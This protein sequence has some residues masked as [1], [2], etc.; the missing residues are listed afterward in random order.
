M[1]RGKGMVGE[2]EWSGNG[3]KIN[4]LLLKA[5][6]ASSNFS[7]RSAM[8]EQQFWSEFFNISSSLSP[9][10]RYVGENHRHQNG[11]FFVVVDTDMDENIGNSTAVSPPYRDNWCQRRSLLC[12]LAVT[13]GLLI[14][15]VLIILLTWIVI[16][17]KRKRRFE[18]E[19]RPS[20]VE[21]QYNGPKMRDTL[22]AP[23]IE[24]LI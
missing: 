16:K 14:F 20:S 11:T 2:W 12:G 6:P 18:G 4:I 17:M 1:V 8:T 9:S 23:V 7:I 22:P 24:G 5:L 19:Y 3:N 13:V 21:R 10:K 15:I